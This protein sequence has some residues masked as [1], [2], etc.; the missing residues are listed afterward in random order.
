[1]SYYSF[2]RPS[3]GRRLSQP[4]SVHFSACLTDRVTNRQ[5]DSQSVHL[6]VILFV[7]LFRLF[8]LYIC[9]YIGRSIHV[10]L[11]RPICEEDLYLVSNSTT[12]TNAQNVV[13]HHPRTRCQQFYNMLPTCWMNEYVNLYSAQ[14]TN[15]LPHVEMLC[16]DTARAQRVANNVCIVEFDANKLYNK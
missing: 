3:E 14:R 1:M 4:R 11:S 8:D 15:I 10:S 9:L 13:Q 2:Y 5:T 12:R 16:S 6:F 7:T